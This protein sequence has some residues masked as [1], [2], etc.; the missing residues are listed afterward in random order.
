MEV[1]AGDTVRLTRNWSTAKFGIV[2]KGTIGTL[3]PSSTGVP[4]LFD[5][6][7]LNTSYTF[8]VVSDVVENYS[9]YE[10]DDIQVI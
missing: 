7:I 3:V 1:K 5:F 6:T 2:V 9:L 10:Y 8:T 4:S